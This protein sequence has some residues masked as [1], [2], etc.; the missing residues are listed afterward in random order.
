MSQQ[1]ENRI[2][3][4]DKFIFKTTKTRPDKW[5]HYV[6]GY[7][8]SVAVILL[9]LFV[10]ALAFG[11]L[12]HQF[13]TWG[14]SEILIFLALI[15]ILQFPVQFVN[16][17]LFKHSQKIKDRELTHSSASN[18]ELKDLLESI[19]KRFNPYW[20]KIPALI[21]MIIGLTKSVYSNFLNKPSPLLDALWNYLPLPVFI[22]GILLFYYSGQQ[23]RKIWINLKAFEAL[24]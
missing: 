21:L 22:V 3:L 10:E 17:L 9:F 6:N 1:I 8:S 15:L 12:I 16:F 23:I 19:A 24:I 13:L 5:M 2:E 7:V 4:I 18:N 14:K 11:T 20:L